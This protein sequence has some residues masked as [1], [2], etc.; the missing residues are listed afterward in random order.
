MFTLIAEGPAH[1][2]IAQRRLTVSEATVKSH[3]N[4]VVSGPL[5]PVALL[6]VLVRRPLLLVVARLR[7]RHGH[8]GAPD[9]RAAS[10]LTAFIGATPFLHAAVLLVLALALPTSALLWLSAGRPVGWAVL[11]VGG[12]ALLRYR[13]RLRD[14][15]RR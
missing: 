1:A 2:E 9:P 6:P 7:D 12:A 5:G 15:G 4:P 14:G 13:S 10:A 8:G 3:I 11:A